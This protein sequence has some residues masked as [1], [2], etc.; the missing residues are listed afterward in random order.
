MLGRL[1]KVR[2]RLVWWPLDLNELVNDDIRSARPGFGAP[3]SADVVV[4]RRYLGQIGTWFGEER[5]LGSA[6]IIDGYYDETSTEPVPLFKYWDD[7]AAV[8]VALDRREEPSVLLQ[9]M[10]ELRALDRPHLRD[11]LAGLH[12]WS[13]HICAQPIPRRFH[14]AMSYD[15]LSP[16]PEFPD[17]EHVIPLRYGGPHWWS[18]LRLAHRS[19]NLS[20]RTRDP[21]LRR[22]FGLLLKRMAGPEYEELSRR[23]KNEFFANYLKLDR[24]SASWPLADAH[25]E[26]PK[27]IDEIEDIPAGNP[28][29]R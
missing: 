11:A 12:G 20:K 28:T 13:C 10:G 6:P 2:W 7:A 21:L 25:D 27:H 26:D 9:A 23:E 16:D 1:H 8:I 4:G 19:C 14:G 17:I 5:A 18:N 15:L 29:A 24:L 3:W 22:D